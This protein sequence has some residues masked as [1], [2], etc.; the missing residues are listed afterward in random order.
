MRIVVEDEIAIPNPAFGAY[1]PELDSAFDLKPDGSVE[2]PTGFTRFQ[3]FGNAQFEQVHGN[4]WVSNWIT[5]VTDTI[6]VQVYIHGTADTE[7]FLVYMW[8]IE[9]RIV[10]SGIHSG[11]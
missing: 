5:V 6:E 9:G 10:S 7:I 4:T 1:Y 8:K 3:D 2:N 11:G